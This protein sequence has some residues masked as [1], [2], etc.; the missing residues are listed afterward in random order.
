MKIY[1][2]TKPPEAPET[3]CV[4]TIVRQLHTTESDSR[5]FD[6]KLFEMQPAT[7]VHS[8]EHKVLVIQGERVVFD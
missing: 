4:K 6:I 3:C 5:Q 2:Y 1:E 7:T 8:S